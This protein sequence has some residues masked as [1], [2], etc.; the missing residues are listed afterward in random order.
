MHDKKEKNNAI[1]VVKVI[2]W[3]VIIEFL[4]R[5]EISK[6]LFLRSQL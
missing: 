6:E 4:L 1:L 2:R 3:Y 5:F